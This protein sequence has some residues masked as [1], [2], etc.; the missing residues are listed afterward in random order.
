[1]TLVTIRQ[2][3]IVLVLLLL[4]ASCEPAVDQDELL[5]QRLSAAMAAAAD[6]PQAGLTIT[7]DGGAVLVSGSID[8]EACGGTRT[9]G[10]VDTIQQNLGA[11]IRAVPGVGAVTFDLRGSR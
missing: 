6:L 3:S 7:V 8:C 1:M 2:L 4:T 5:L 11:V 10:G 9:P